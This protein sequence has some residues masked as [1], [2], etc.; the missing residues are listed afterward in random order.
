VPVL[1]ENS[2]EQK[3][4]EFRLELA[5]R[6]GQGQKLYLDTHLKGFGVL[7]GKKSKTYV[8]QRD[9]PG[10]KT[11]RVTIGRH[12]VC[13]TAQ[14]K[15]KALEFLA[16]MASGEDPNATARANA[17]RSVTLGEAA[18]L[19]REKIDREEKSKATLRGIDYMFM[20]LNDWGKR[21]LAEI[22][23][24]EVYKRHSQI[25]KKSGPS[26]AN[27]VMRF[28]RVIYNTA[29]KIHEDLP[30]NP[31]VAVNW[32]KETR[33]QE[34]IPFPKLPEWYKKVQAIPNSV[35]QDYQLFVLFTGLRSTDAANVRWEDIDFEAGTLHRPNPKGG[36]KRAFTLPLSGY[37]LEILKKRKVENTLFGE[38]CPW[39]FPTRRRNGSVSPIQEPKE[40]K[41]GLPSPHRLRD[42]YTSAANNAGLSPYD[43]DVLTNH[44]PA[45]GSVTA[46]YINQGL[47]HL[48]VYWSSEF[49]GHLYRALS[50][51]Y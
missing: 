4:L 12:G 45:N 29:S 15:E 33:R 14:A 48:R 46:G 19:Y 31:T 32:F 36:R 24:A 2:T 41:R 6:H 35:R 16:R 43:I 37:I 7:V 21:P 50:L 47:E 18:D 10:R 23:R 28:F 5:I 27:H 42:T 49:E 39:V 1:S 8:V 51:Q 26:A 44:R 40:T 3:Y 38:D 22:T 13:T 34:P 25:E 20:H 30:A 11:R 9:L 17:A